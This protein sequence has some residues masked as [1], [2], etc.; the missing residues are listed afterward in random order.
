M[1]STH[2]RAARAASGRGFDLKLIDQTLRTGQSLAE[3]TARR[4]TSRIAVA[5]SAMPG[6]ILK[7]R[8]ADN[9]GRLRVGCAI[10][11][12]PCILDDVAREF[13]GHGL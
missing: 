3:T 10:I 8:P 13:G 9:P 12:A 11:P 2:D 1:K 4:K 7:I 5:M 6:P